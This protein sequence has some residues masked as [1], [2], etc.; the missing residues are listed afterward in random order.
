M[1][2]KKI[3]ILYSTAGMG[4]KKAAFAL[5]EAFRKYATSLDVEIADVMEY[6]NPVYR[7]AY[8]RVYV[9][10]MNRAKWLWG[11]LYGFSNNLLWERITGPLRGFVDYFSLPGLGEYVLKKQ[12]DAVVATHFLL[13]SIARKLRKKGVRSRLYTIITDYGPHL[14]WL[15]EAIDRYFVGSQ[16]VKDALEILQVPPDRI[17]VSGIPVSGDFIAERDIARIRSKY[18]LSPDRKTVFLMSGGF[19]VGPIKQMLISLNKCNSDIQVIAVCGHNVRVKEDIEKIKDGLAYPAR[20]LGFTDRV[21]ELMAVSDIMISKAGGISVTEALN[22]RVPLILYGS[23]PGQETWNEQ[24]LVKEGAAEKS[25]NIA[26]I[27]AITDRILIS[28]DAYQL[29]MHNIDRIRRPDAAS[30]V[31]ESIV[32]DIK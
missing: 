23:I 32:D 24:L 16:S 28:E 31:A 20:V 27:P 1:R 12:P 4:H 13:P 2:K 29:L 11:K 22:A 25:P 14:W 30:V 8:T 6:S 26:S 21:P 10:L 5:L 19:G 18:D 17:A 9:F 3:L 15:S 7:F